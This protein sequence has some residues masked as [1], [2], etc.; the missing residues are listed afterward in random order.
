MDRNSPPF[1]VETTEDALRDTEAFIRW[2]REELASPLVHPVVT[3]RFLPTCSEPL[4]RGLGE[5]VRRHPGV[6]VQSHI[7]ESADQV[8]FFFPSLKAH[9]TSLVS[10]CIYPPPHGFALPPLIHARQV[11]FTAELS[12]CH[13]TH[14]DARVY[15]SCGLLTPRTVLA[16]GVH[17]RP[18]ELELFKE[19]CVGGYWRYFSGNRFL[20][21]YWRADR[22]KHIS[23]NPC[24]GTA[25]SH[26]PLS[27]FFF[28]HGVLTARK[29]MDMGIK[30][31]WKNTSFIHSRTSR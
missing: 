18:S 6:H 15:D 19:R 9:N 24:S 8:I 22:L 7:S 16:H 17:L 12:H 26:C 21:G 28:A 23:F 4:L 10:V 27:N 31:S 2:T 1:Y 25:I 29:V 5:I 20:L 14:R 11:E 3:P 30:A 13:S